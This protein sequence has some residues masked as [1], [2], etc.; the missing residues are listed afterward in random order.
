MP[1]A[2][3]VACLKKLFAPALQAEKQTPVVG[4]CICHSLKHVLLAEHT[5]YEAALDKYKLSGVPD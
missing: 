4:M 5:F 3:L 1:A 2:L